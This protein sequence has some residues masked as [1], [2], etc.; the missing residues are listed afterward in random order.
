MGIKASRQYTKPHKKGSLTQGNRQH[1]NGDNH[2]NGHAEPIEAAAGHGKSEVHANGITGAAEEAKGQ[3]SSKAHANGMGLAEEAVPMDE[4]A[5]VSEPDLFITGAAKEKQQRSVKRQRV[6]D[7][8]AAGVAP[9]D[10]IDAVK[11][12]P[13]MLFDVARHSKEE[14]R[15]S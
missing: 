7:G 14:V 2:A 10:G 12:P 13:A 11:E 8:G 3:A 4:H 5:A 6:D 1:Q 9:A 15:W